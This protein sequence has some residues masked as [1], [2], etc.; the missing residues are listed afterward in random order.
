V[1]TSPYGNP[2]SP[3][4]V[5]LAEAGVSQQRVAEA[6]GVAGMTISR[7]L[8]GV[9]PMPGR[10]LVALVDLVGEPRALEILDAIPE[11]GEQVH[12]GR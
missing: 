11:V 9:R 2:V 3:A 12:D 1:G 10:L 8:S 5:L 7:A 4:A 6:T